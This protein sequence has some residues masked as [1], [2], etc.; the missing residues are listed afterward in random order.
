MQFKGETV[1]VFTMIHS[2]WKSGI[3]VQTESPQSG[4]LLRTR[5]TVAPLKYRSFRPLLKHSPAL[6][7]EETEQN[8]TDWRRLELVCPTHVPLK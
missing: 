1:T 2:G 4:V 6:H 7:T 3:F 8:G 5:N